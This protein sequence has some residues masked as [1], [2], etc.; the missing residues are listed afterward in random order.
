MLEDDCITLGLHHYYFMINFLGHVKLLDKK[1]VY[2]NNT[3]LELD[4][5]ALNALFNAHIINECPYN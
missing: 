5:V 3:P 4:V 2:I 1:K